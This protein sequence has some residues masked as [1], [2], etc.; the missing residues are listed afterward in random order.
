MRVLAQVIASGAAW[1]AAVNRAI[2]GVMESLQSKGA[3]QSEGAA[4][5]GRVQAGTGE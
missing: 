4:H 3:E 2:D 1:L 5:V